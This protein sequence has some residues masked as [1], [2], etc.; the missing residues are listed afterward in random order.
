MHQKS[1]LWSFFLIRLSN[2]YPHPKHPVFFIFGVLNQKWYFLW[3]ANFQIANFYRNNFPKTSPKI[4]FRIS[5]FS[6]LF[7][8]SIS[9]SLYFI[10]LLS[11]LVAY[12]QESIHSF[13]NSLFISFYSSFLC[14]LSFLLI[15]LFFLSFFS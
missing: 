13:L 10:L 6:S 9:L 1:H 14:I 7:L 2:H 15:F 12:M 8:F 5:S 3:Q 4:H 11:F